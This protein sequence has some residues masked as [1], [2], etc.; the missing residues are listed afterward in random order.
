MHRFAVL[1]GDGNGC[2][3]TGARS[4]GVIAQ[5]WR[6]L[7]CGRCAAQIRLC[8]ECD[9]GQRYCGTACARAQRMA[10]QR[11][12]SKVYQQSRRGAQLHA[13]RMQRCRERA[14]REVKIPAPKVTQQSATQAA[15]ETSFSTLIRATRSRI[16]EVEE[17]LAYG[18]ALAMRAARDATARSSSAERAGS[19][20]Y[21]KHAW[22]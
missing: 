15:S 22:T 5:T 1:P 7:Q 11:L 20:P 17:D 12:A 16:S 19:R 18:P 10:A 6:L 21:S 2:P 3:K 14:M 8:S 4:G 9:R 13:A